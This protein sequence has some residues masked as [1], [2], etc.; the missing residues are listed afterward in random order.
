MAWDD[1]DFG[2]LGGWGTGGLGDWGGTGVVGGGTDTAGGIGDFLN[3]FD[4]GSG[5]GEFGSNL[6]VF[7]NQTGQ[8]IPFSQAMQID[9]QAAQEF[10]G[11]LMP[12]GMNQGGTGGLFSGLSGAQLAGLGIGGATAGLGLIGVI[13]K[14]IQGDTQSQQTIQKTLGSGTPEEQA[15][16]KQALNQFQTLNQFAMGSPTGL[17]QQLGARAPFEEAAFQSG[18]GGL[19]NQGQ[20]S[21]Q[22]LQTLLPG[23]AGITPNFPQGGQ[24]FSGI[25]PQGPG[26]PPPPPPAPNIPMVGGAPGTPGTPGT[27]ATPG[28]YAAGQ[29]AQLWEPGMGGYDYLTSLDPNTPIS[30]QGNNWVG[31]GGRI[32]GDVSSSQNPSLAASRGIMPMVG[33]PGTPGTAAI[34]G[35]PGTPDPNFAPQPYSYPGQGQYN[36]VNNAWQWSPM[37]LGPP[38]QWAPT[39]NTGPGGAVGGAEQGGVDGNI[40]MLPTGLPYPITA[41]LNLNEGVAGGG[42]GGQQ[43]G[44]GSQTGLG[45]MANQSQF[46]NQ[47]L[48][49]LLPGL[50]GIPPSMPSPPPPAASG[51]VPGGLPSGGGT[52]GGVMPGGLP[53]LLGGQE[54]ILNQLLQAAQGNMS[55]Q[56]L[57]LIEQAYQPQLGNIATQAIEAA[58]QRGFAGGA[59]LLNQAPAGALAGPALSALQGQIAQAKLGFPAMLGQAAGAFSTPAALR[60]TGTSNLMNMN[61]NILQS[62]LGVGNQGIQNR[63]NFMGAAT[64]QL[65]TQG[66]LGNVGR[67]N[68]GTT[69]STM[70]Q[71]FSLL[72]AFAPLAGLLGGAGGLLGGISGSN[73]SGVGR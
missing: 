9:P 57:R 46:S 2:D 62:L 56:L 58:R 29:L 42:T 6:M 59:E 47:L 37:L 17:M 26:M 38:T 31:P 33:T 8:T 53:S 14:A 73:L 54:Q 4:P 13:Q 36:W 27:A 55:P 67:L 16:L 64:G 45:G 21:N 28:G 60:L 52:G 10:I 70:N 41:S 11:P 18:L 15:A 22:L 50:T 49:T 5:L 66:N 24:Q 71:P 72:D 63:L 68:T 35:T 12:A 3:L 48:Q 43:G 34:P 40:G 23:L 32:V 1:F 25:P 39:P 30:I 61:Q 51:S 44:A 19:A 20:I 65:G 69:T 7:D